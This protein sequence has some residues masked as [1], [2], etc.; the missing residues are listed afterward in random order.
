MA[1]DFL[2]IPVSGVGVESLFNTCRDICHYRRSRLDPSTIHHL[3]LLVL[4]DRF[5][6][7]DDYQAPRDDADTIPESKT[8]S[9]TGDDPVDNEGAISEYEELDEIR[10][11]EARFTEVDKGEAILPNATLP[12]SQQAVSDELFQSQTSVRQRPARRSLLEPGQYRRLAGYRVA[13]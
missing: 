12:E 3:M 1:R 2:A 9:G 11:D 13:Q 4:T 7:K 8:D 10:E 6:L 5:K